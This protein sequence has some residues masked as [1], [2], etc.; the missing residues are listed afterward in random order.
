MLLSTAA[1][2]VMVFLDH[3]GLFHGRLL[4]HCT[5]DQVKLEPACIRP[6]VEADHIVSD[7]YGSF[8]PAMLG[9]EPGPAGPADPGVGAG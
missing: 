1:D 4:S 3:L 5:L 7:E 9:V 2:L 8:P 6:P